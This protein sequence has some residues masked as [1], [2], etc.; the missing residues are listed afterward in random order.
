MTDLMGMV[1]AIAPIVA[2]L[3]W[4][5]VRD[6][7]RDQADGVR[8]D[9]NAVVTRALGGESLVAIEVAPPTRWRAGQIR[10]GVPGGYDPLLA[11]AS[12]AVLQRMPPDYELVTRPAG[13]RG[14]TGARRTN[15]WR[16]EYS[17]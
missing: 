6:R 9:I 11:C 12:E 17:W 2:A 10:L 4:C 1:I 5:N 15:T 14:S 3:A 8:A 7:R 13:P 16:S